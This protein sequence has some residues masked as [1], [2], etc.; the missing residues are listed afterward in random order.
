MNNNERIATELMGWRR[1][2]FDA[3]LTDDG[4]VKNFDPY[5]NPAH[6]TMV[7]EVIRVS[8]RNTNDCWMQIT[9]CNVCYNAAIISSAEDVLIEEDGDTWMAALCNAVIAYLDGVKDE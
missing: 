2:H 6:A 5:K 8:L 3:W 4:V 9:I 1:L 7:L